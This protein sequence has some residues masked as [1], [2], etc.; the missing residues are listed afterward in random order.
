MTFA[1]YARITSTVDPVNPQDVATKNYVD[2]RTPASYPRGF[3]GVLNGPSVQTDCSSTNTLL[4]D[5]VVPVVNNRH[6]R[7]TGYGRGAQVTATGIS[8]FIFASPS[9]ITWDSTQSS[10]LYI[11]YSSSLAVGA[12]LLGTGVYSF[13]ANTTGNV[14]IRV[15][16]SS[17]AGAL[18][19]AANNCF[20]FVEDMGG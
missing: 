6:Y 4:V 1:E 10:A 11:T 18:R 13:V 12:T 15:W 8:Q 16:G 14:N 7:A 5:L 20:C 19:V 3:L 2:G 9:A 17:N